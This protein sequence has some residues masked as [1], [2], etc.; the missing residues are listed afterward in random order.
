MAQ[1]HGRESRTPQHRPDAGVRLATLRHLAHRNHATAVQ[2]HS[3]QQHEDTKQGLLGVGKLHLQFPPGKAGRVQG[4]SQPAPGSQDA[5]QLRQHARNVHVWKCHL[6]EDAVHAGVGYW[7]ALS[8]TAEV[9]PAPRVVLVT[10]DLNSILLDVDADQLPVVN[11]HPEP[12][13]GIAA[14]HP[15]SRILSIA[16]PKTSALTSATVARR[17]VQF[18]WVS[19]FRGPGEPGTLRYME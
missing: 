15:R 1:T 14:P 4:R 10:R 11:R 12:R 18:R 13:P 3:I 19:G 9:A 7:N 5:V 17:K 6:A 8:A 16:L 2:D